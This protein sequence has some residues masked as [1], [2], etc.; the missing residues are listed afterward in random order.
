MGGL[1]L[2]VVRWWFVNEIV[3]DEIVESFLSVREGVGC[4]IV[5]F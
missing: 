3:L 2:I 4:G 5:L 1:K